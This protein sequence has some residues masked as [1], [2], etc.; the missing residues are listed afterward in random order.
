MSLTI[1]GLLR[2]TA[3]DQC[4]TAGSV[5]PAQIA[6]NKND[7][8]PTAQLLQR[9][10][11]DA[12]R[13][14]TGMVAGVDAELRIVANVGSFD[15]VLKNADSAS[16]AANRFAMTSGADVTL[17]AGQMAMAVYDSTTAR[18]RLAKLA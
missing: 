10:S 13:N 2:A 9:W 15:I 7:Y 14:V 4:A 12:S 17:T 1:N 5:T 3:A 11:S 8:E 18:W 6:G 16:A